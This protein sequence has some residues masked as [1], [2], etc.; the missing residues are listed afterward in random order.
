[1]NPARRVSR[2]LALLTLCAALPTGT[3]FAQGAPAVV[4]QTVSSGGGASSGGTVSVQ[5]T[6]GQT[7]AHAPAVVD[8][9]VG[10]GYWRAPL[11][12]NDEIACGLLTGQSNVFHQTRLV[13]AAVEAGGPGTLH[14]L[15][16]IRTD[17][18]HPQW[19]AGIDAS[20]FWTMTS[21]N[22]AGLPAAGYLLALTFPH[23]GFGNPFACRWSGTQWQCGQ[24]TFD[25]T[26][27]TRAGV[28]TLSDWVVA[29]LSVP[30]ELIH[31]T[32]E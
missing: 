10:G 23:P 22:T 4:W 24:T 9:M 2:V 13:T 30:V 6:L 32:A 8:P 20:A 14:C 7:W 16:M 5:S 28:T 15:R 19:V 3:A 18:Q 26:T 12:D 27:V 11:R 1:M 29:S 25:L 17:A 21:F 31:F